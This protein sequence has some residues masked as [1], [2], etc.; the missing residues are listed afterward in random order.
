[1]AKSTALS[2]IRVKGGC[3]CIT[4]T[5]HESAIPSLVALAQEKVEFMRL[6]GVLRL[7]VGG[8]IILMETSEQEEE[9][10]EEGKD[11]VLIR[12]VTACCTAAVEF[13]YT[14]CWC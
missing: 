3:I 2:D 8:I 4:W 7:T 11:P 1:M 6:V 10:K 5:T 9:K 12:A 13:L 14:Q